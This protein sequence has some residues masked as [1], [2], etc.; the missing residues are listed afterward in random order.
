MWRLQ[1][2]R[3]EERSWYDWF[4]N[5]LWR[6][7]K[8]WRAKEIRVTTCYLRIRKTKIRRRIL[9]KITLRKRRK[10]KENEWSFGKI[11]ITLRVVTKERGGN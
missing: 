7:I 3:N 5:S 1:W 2:L 8:S 6:S 9:E 10:W 4:W 11:K